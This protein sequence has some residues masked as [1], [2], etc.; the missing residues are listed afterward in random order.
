MA[1]GSWDEAYR[2]GRVPWDIG[3][4]QPAFVRLAGEGELVGRVLDVGCGSGEHAL[5]ASTIG[6]EVTGVDVSH[7]AIERALTLHGDTPASRWVQLATVAPV[8]IVTRLASAADD[9][10]P[11][12]SSA[13]S[14]RSI[15]FWSSA[16][17]PLIDV[18]T[19][20]RCRAAPAMSDAYSA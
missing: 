2:G 6:L 7:V 20:I 16:A 9:N 1:G 3:R 5:L 4:P 18:M 12:D 15:S 11:A 17:A 13:R 14:R 19:S 10:S 8:V